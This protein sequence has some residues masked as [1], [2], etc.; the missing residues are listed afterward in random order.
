MFKRTRI[1][2]LVLAILFVLILGS[3]S[4]FAVDSAYNYGDEET[5]FEGELKLDKSTVNLFKG[6]SHTLKV[7]TEPELEEDEMP[8]LSFESSNDDIAKVDEKGKITA[9]SKG[10][11]TITISV[12][13]GTESVECKVVV[14][15]RPVLKMPVKATSISVNKP[16]LTLKVNKVESIK[17]TF[18]P[19]N[20]TIGALRWASSNTKIA[21]VNLNGNIIAKSPGRVDITVTESISKKTAKVVLTVIK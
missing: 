14:N 4:V 20:A 1:F 7:K 17:T 21:T 13:D 5:S 11:A 8:E 18:K 2:S 10:N 12:V 15:E 9:V 16:V 6:E 19:T 3:S